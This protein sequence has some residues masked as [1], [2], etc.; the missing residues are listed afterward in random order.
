MAAI[1]KIRSWGPWLVGI[2]GLALF[3]F[4]ATD[5][6]R[7]CETSSNQ[8]R[9][10]VGEVM[11]KK[12]SYQDYQSEVEE[13]K[14]VLKQIGQDANVDEEQL[15]EYIWQDYVRNSIIASEAEKLGL[16]V[17]DREMQDIL[18]KGEHPLLQR[19]NM[20]YLLPQFFNAQ[21][22]IFDFNNVA[23]IYSVLQQQNPETYT[24]FDRYWKTVEKILRQALLS[25]KYLTL[26]KSCMLSNEVSA[27]MAFDG[28]NTE[29]Q[30]ELAS[31]A[32]SSINDNDVTISDND[33]KAKYD[34]KK[35]MFKWNR[36]TRDIKYVVCNVEPSETDL[37]NLRN[38]LLKA[39]EEL[40]QDSLELTEILGTHRSTIS[41]RGKDMPYNEKGLKALCPELFAAL[42]TMAEMQVTEP[43]RANFNFVRYQQDGRPVADQKNIMAVARLNR[44]Y[45]DV[46][47]I[48]YQ[49]LG[50]PGQSLEDATKR[51]DSLVAV[52]K[53]G[54]SMD[55]VATSLGQN[56]NTS[57]MSAD[58][59]QTLETVDPT[60]KT[61]YTALHN[62]AVNTPSYVKT[63]NQI[64]LFMVKERRMAKLYDVA[65][66]SNE[67]NFS[68][69]TEEKTYNNFSEFV[70][71]CTSPDDLE[72][73]AANYNY[74]VLEQKNLQSNSP[75]IGTNEPLANTKDAVKWVFA[76]AQEG[77][78]SEIFRNS[79]D[80]RFMAVAVT[81]VHPVGYLDQQ[82]VADFL[83]TEVM[84]DKKA[85]MLIKKLDGAKTVAD[86]KQKGALVDTIGQITFPTTVNV[87]GM[88]ERGLSGAVAA[89]QPGQTVNHVVKGTNGVFLF[90]VI[91]R[92]QREGVNYDPREQEITLIRE[93]MRIVEAGA[94]DILQEKAKVE[95]NRYLF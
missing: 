62:A 46:D 81:K 35:E 75:Y 55:S 53:G 2:I 87:K 22:G 3:G 17:T 10:Q 37:D 38:G 80:G 44:R 63:A 77:S 78:I 9:Q 21:T 49:V 12:L 28:R 16:S 51:A 6:T 8:A 30:I 74:L 50:V 13:F 29:S 90:N 60:I 7:S 18:A 69:D 57:W 70:S 83:R 43:I 23:Q 20:P 56:L 89:T 40:K 45:Q 36:E 54:V 4:I 52:I 31:L 24:E 65:I 58:S 47:S 42:D 5:F 64:F 48:S 59:Y 84:R 1:G 72:K 92:K 32:F 14:N 11:G 94:F 73:N 25:E 79:A 91:D 26:L 15:H 39:A 41:Y 34:E 93:A 33:L 76:K 71:K 86:A 61:V 66:V 19:G 68:T 67:V 95:D 88:R 85:E 27:K 82:S